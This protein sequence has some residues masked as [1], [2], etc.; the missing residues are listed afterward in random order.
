MNEFDIFDQSNACW[1]RSVRL[2]VLRP[3][4][5][6]VREDFDTPLLIPTSRIPD[7]INLVHLSQV[8]LNG[9]RLG[10]PPPG[11]CL[12]F[13]TLQASQRLAANPDGPPCV[14]YWAGAC[15]VGW[16]RDYVNRNKCGRGKFVAPTVGKETEPS[17]GA[18][19]CSCVIQYF[20]RSRNIPQL[21]A[22]PIEPVA[23][24]SP[25]Q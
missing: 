20:S 21:L 1:I 11:R 22:I 3:A 5:A 19:R 10:E 4:I 9:R 23:Q 25:G 15:D 13:P 24:S 7:P 17:A 18:E 14:R 8:L 6:S 16:T 2:D 12:G